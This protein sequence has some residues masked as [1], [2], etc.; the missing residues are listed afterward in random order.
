ML[1]T[2]R[3]YVGRTA[4]V[5]IYLGPAEAKAARMLCYTGPQR[6]LEKMALAA[7]Q[8]QYVSS[9][10]AFCM[11]KRVVVRKSPPRWRSRATASS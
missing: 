11:S 7:G 10:G 2:G 8:A 1:D 6:R 4:S 9:L 5:Q 3:I